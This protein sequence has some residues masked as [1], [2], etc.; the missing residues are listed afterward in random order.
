MRNFNDFFNCSKNWNFT[1]FIS[2]NL[3][4]LFL[5]SINSVGHL[6]IFC[7][8]IRFILANLD[9]LTINSVHCNLDNLFFN[10]IKFNWNFFFI[11]N[12]HNFLYNFFHNFIYFYYLGQYCL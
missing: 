11:V 10:Y 12:R 2:I 9:N 7:N 6:F 1:F 4:D 5:N 8:F 3:L